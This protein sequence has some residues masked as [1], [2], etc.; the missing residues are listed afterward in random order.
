MLVPATSSMVAPPM[1][2]PG[3]A[4]PLTPANS[5]YAL[6]GS[7]AMA[8]VSDG[9]S[10]EG[11]RDAERAAKTAAAAAAAGGGTAEPTYN[12]AAA[13]VSP[14]QPTPS[15]PQPTPSTAS[16]SRR[17]CSAATMSLVAAAP[18]AAPNAAA[19]M[20]A[21]LPPPTTPKRRHKL[22]SCAS[23]LRLPLPAL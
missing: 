1:S 16:S 14:P 7:G 15:P 3:A 6:Q 22:A 21:R 18:Q 17:R 2:D 12:P 13:T 19:A 23:A 9:A 10:A 11:I 5:S 4:P 20:R 8:D